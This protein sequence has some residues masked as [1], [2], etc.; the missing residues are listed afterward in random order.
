MTE[1]SSVA[2]IVAAIIATGSTLAAYVRRAVRSSVDNLASVLGERLETKA[3]VATLT[4]RVAVLEERLSIRPNH[5][6]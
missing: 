5:R 1:W 2:V 3:T 6:R 4:T